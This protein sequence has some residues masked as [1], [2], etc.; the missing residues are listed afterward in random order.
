MAIWQVEVNKRFDYLI[1]GLIVKP[2]E[3][4]NKYGGGDLLDHYRHVQD[5][6]TSKI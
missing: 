5:I 2:N 1:W 3:K 6:S 4:W